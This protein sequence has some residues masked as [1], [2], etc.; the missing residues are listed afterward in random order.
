MGGVVRSDNANRVKTNELRMLLAMAQWGSMSK[1]AAH[2]NISQSAISKAIGAL[3]ATLGVQLFDRTPQGVEPTLYGRAL[4]K[5][6]VAVFDDLRQGI[7]EIEFLA[8]PT[9]GELRIGSTEP[10]VPGL[11]AV[12]LDRLSRRYPRITF[13]VTQAD[14]DTLQYRELRGRN[15]D[16]VIGR[17]HRSVAEEDMEVDVLFHDQLYVTVGTNNRWLRRRGTKLAEL[18]NEPWTLPPYD[19][20]IGSLMAEAFQSSGLP[21]PRL[22]VVC[23][24]IQ[25]HNALLATG[26][27]LS[28]LSGSMLRFSGK[29]LSIKALPIELPIKPRPVGIITLKNRTVSPVAQLFID[30]AREVAKPLARGN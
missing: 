7:R 16:F 2:L 17:V 24:S 18:I 30:C 6:G 11:V 22:S 14:F 26:R 25:M 23:F 27:F 13:H 29:H 10:L 1:A 9:A 28:M 12:V 15:I 4:L 8:D 19:S 20:Q 3:E 21:P 5:S